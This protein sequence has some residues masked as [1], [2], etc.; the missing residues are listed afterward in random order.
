[1]K[2]NVERFIQSIKVPN[3]AKVIKYVLENAD[4]NIESYNLMELENFVLSLKP[5][6]QKAII[7]ICYVLR[8][9]AKWL[10]DEKIVNNNNMYQMVQSLNKDLLWKKAKPHAKK[11]FI[12][13]EQFKNITHEIGVYEEF[14]TLYYELL[15]RC[16]YEGIYSDDL[17]VIKNLRSSDIG[18][19]IVV[20]H[21]DNGHTYKLKISQNLAAD[22]K[23]L[24]AIDYW[25]RKNRYGAFKVDI[26]GVYNDSVFKIENRNVDSEGS[27]K[28]SYYAKLRKLS[29]EYVEYNLLPLQLYVSGIMHRIK[30]ELDNYD[31]TLQDAFLNDIY[32]RTA[33]SIISKE[34]VRSNY[35]V[36]LNNFR[37]MVKGHLESF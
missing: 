17:S 33:H 21:E 4:E 13:Y 26:K 24:A 34:L 9:Y 22:L 14:N 8:L 3:T 11:K 19:N 23:K 25:E 36:Q 7:T 10:E 5:S 31:I 32:N 27:Y 18:E 6:N 2:T 12:S 28:F 35:N 1:M 16:I 20:L 29:K 30:I 15:F 37:D